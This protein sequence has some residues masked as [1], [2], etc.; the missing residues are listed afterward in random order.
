MKAIV[1]HTYGS[2][3]VLK[4]EEI[5]RGKISAKACSVTT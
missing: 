5:I 1:F 3:D 4:C 2:P